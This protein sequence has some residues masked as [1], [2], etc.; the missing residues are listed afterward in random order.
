MKLYRFSPMQSKQELIEALEYVVTQT[1]ELCRNIIT[2]SL[3]VTSVTIFAHYPNEYERLINILRELGTPQSEV[4]GFK[5]VLREPLTVRDNVITHFRIRPPD[6]YRMQVGCNDFDVKD[7]TAFRKEY[8]EAYPHN[9]R[10]I[11]RQDYEM[12]EFF[13]PDYDVLAYVLSRPI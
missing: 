9:L 7:F 12:I 2:A 10:L 5:V 4:N 1:S 3:P 13:D 8:A 6:P 11:Q